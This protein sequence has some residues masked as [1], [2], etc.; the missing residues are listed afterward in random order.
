MGPT[1][2]VSPAARDPAASDVEHVDELNPASIEAVPG[3]AD[4]GGIPSFVEPSVAEGEATEGDPG[5]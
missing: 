5:P 4:R 3:P 1:Q 2:A